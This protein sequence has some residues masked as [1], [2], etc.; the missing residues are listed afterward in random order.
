MKRMKKAFALMLAVVMVVAMT[1]T[2]FADE[3]E[4][5]SPTPPTGPGSITLNGISV[6]EET[7]GESTV[8]VP[9]ARYDVYQILTLDS[10]NTA[11]DKYEYRLIDAWAEFFAPGELQS[12]GTY[13]GRGAGA[14]YVTISENNV[15]T[16]T[17]STD[18]TTRATFA[19]EALKYVEEK[20]T[21]TPNAIPLTRTTAV[22]AQYTLTSETETDSNGVS[23][24][25]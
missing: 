9:A 7:Q 8:T 10:Y 12:D 6:K 22:A 24:T 21:A 23:K 25:V 16:W 20:N 5:P 18:S 17:A 3:E 2:S 19:K 4:T 14:D 1:V 13:T 15:F 11:L